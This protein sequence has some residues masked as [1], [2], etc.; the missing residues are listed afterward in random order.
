M[1]E[2]LARGETDAGFLREAG[3]RLWCALF[4]TDRRDVGTLFERARGA[5]T[6]DARGGLRLRLRVEDAALARLPWELLYSRRDD[7]FL[8]TDAATAVVRYVELQRPIRQLETGFPVRM[9][10]V[11]PQ[12]EDLDAAAERRTLEEATADLVDGGRL[13][14][15]W[16]DGCVPIGRVSDALLEEPHHVLH[17]VGHGGFEDEQAYLLLDHLGG[18]TAP[19]GHEEFASLLRNHPTMKLVVLNSCQGAETSSTRPLVGMAPELVKC[20]VPAVVA[21]KYPLYD[22]QAVLFARE[23]YRCLFQGHDRGRVEVAVSHA[24][25]RL[26]GSF[27]GDRVLATPVLFTRAPEGVLFSFLGRGALRDVPLRRRALDRTEAAIRTHETNLG[28]LEDE[29]ERREERL[30]LGRARRRV[31]WRNRTLAAVLAVGLGLSLLASLRVFDRLP[32]EWKVESYAVW[33]GNAFRRPEFSDAIALVATDQAL[34]A[35]WRARHARLLDRLSHARAKVVAF[36]ERMRSEQEADAALADAIR[37]ARARGTEVVLAAGGFD[38]H[39]P[40][41][42]RAVRDAATAWGVA[43]LGQKWVGT[44]A[45]VPLVTSKEGWPPSPGL[46]AFSL[47]AVL[48]YRG[49]TL[50]RVVDADAVGDGAETPGRM[51]TLNPVSGRLVPLAFSDRERIRWASAGCEALAPGDE[52]GT[53]I[54]DHSAPGPLRARTLRYE[55]VETGVFDAG[56]V[57][58]RI[59]VVGTAREPFRILRGLSRETRS[60]MELHADA[61]NTLLSGVTLRPAPEAWQLVITMVMAAIG[62]ALRSAVLERRG[63]RAALA[64]AALLYLAADVWLY[65]SRQLLLNTLFQLGA[66]CAAY[67]IVGW[68]GTRWGM[69]TTR[70]EGPSKAARLAL[71]AFLPLLGG[72]A[73]LGGF[74]RLDGV[75]KGGEAASGPQAQEVR[76]VRGGATVRTEPGMR[77]LKG[78]RITTGTDSRAVLTFDAGWEVV[79]E[80]QT[81]LEILNPTIFVRF[82][83]A[84]ATALD[85]VREVLKAQTEYVVAAP[86]TTQYVVEARG[87]T[88]SVTVL[89]GRVRV[90]S[91][92]RAWPATVYRASER[93]TVVGA[94]RPQRMAPLDGQQLQQIR[95]RLESVRRVFPPRTPVP[96]T[97]E[98]PD[99]SG[100]DYQDAV[101]RLERAGLASVTEPVIGARGRPGSVVGQSHRA[102]TRVRP[103]TRVVVRYAQPAPPR[104]DRV[105]RPPVRDTDLRRR[106][107]TVPDV[108]GRSIAQAAQALQEAGLALGDHPRETSLTVR[109]QSAEPRSAVPCGTRVNLTADVIR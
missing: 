96:G 54:I 59:V 89:E 72:C 42:S 40:R 81:E 5:R 7:S 32:P 53:R 14:V 11:M 29:G 68:L 105:T 18:G 31:R 16:L 21:M 44:T 100:R 77:L 106:L 84:I 101:A 20:G 82:G 33:I 17:F 39:T 49:D 51:A 102:G 46:P 83:Q 71:L 25:N 95:S 41:L 3:A 23:F 19:A 34:T 104:P 74:G 27:P 75:M 56:R 86:E 108:R 78:D 103:G 22:R 65:A 47:A 73:T 15:T 57:A 91:R 43:C 79:L 24:R 67:A 70:N 92:T 58:G 38:G 99:L 48:A 69:H 6:A 62:G 1:E 8:A 12:A 2:R 66:L 13:E 76:V 61:V 63:R 10:V 9:L 37:R 55:D 94:A 45:I 97:V 93:G 109:G 90:A 4:E 88:F 30:E 36:D 64:A 50:A 52:V 28:L 107:C 80:P 60:G 26:A 85:R 98:V 87:D 35:D